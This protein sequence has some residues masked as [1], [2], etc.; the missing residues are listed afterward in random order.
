MEFN[1]NIANET[2]P[3]ISIRDTGILINKQAVALIGSPEKIVIGFDEKNMII[4]LKEY[5]GSENVKSY[6]F[7]SKMKYGMVRI[8]CKNFVKYLSSLTGTQF[9]HAIRY[10]AKFDAEERILYIP[11]ARDKKHEG[12]ED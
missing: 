8:G 12:G 3:Y 5:D 6:K 4:G 9:D 11:L 2:T 1:W 10:E 7:Y